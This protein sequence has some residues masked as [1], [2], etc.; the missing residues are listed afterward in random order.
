[1]GFYRSNYPT[2]SVKALKEPVHPG[3]PGCCQSK[4][5]PATCFLGDLGTF[6]STS[7]KLSKSCTEGLDELVC[8]PQAWLHD[9]GGCFIFL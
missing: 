6:P 1:M 8:D 7:R 9:Q 5:D 4:S 2:N 3:C